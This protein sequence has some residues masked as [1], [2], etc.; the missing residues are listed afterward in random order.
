MIQTNPQTHNALP[1]GESGIS[2]SL[3]T[4][5]ATLLSK[6]AGALHEKSSGGGLRETRSEGLGQAADW[7][8]QSAEYV[9]QADMQ[10]VKADVENQIR[11]NP[12]RS[13]LVAGAVGLFLGA[14]IRRR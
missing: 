4:K 3:R 9:K 5:L 7:L 1:E 10:Q 13:L 6:A 2:G 11:R 14:L 12:G 8:D